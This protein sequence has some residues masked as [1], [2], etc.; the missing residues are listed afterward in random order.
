MTVLVVLEALAL[1]LLGVLV[2]G[3]LRSHAEILRALH[4]LGV[5]IGDPASETASDFLP[6]PDD[7]ASLHGRAIDISGTAPTGDSLA[8]AVAGRRLTLLAFLSSGCLTCREFWTAF[9][10]RDFDPPG[11]ARVVIVTKGTEAESPAVIRTLAPAAV[12]TVLSSQAWTDY[13]V[14]GAPYF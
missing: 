1:L 14:P 8:V 12:P 10:R 11:G 2:A 3:L 7:A 4:D 5:G 13:R 9:G 6:R